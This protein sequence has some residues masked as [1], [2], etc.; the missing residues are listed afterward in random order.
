MQNE[1]GSLF[2][3][4]VLITY[5]GSHVVSLSMIINSTKVECFLH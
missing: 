4:S 1:C 3:V 2:H 5:I